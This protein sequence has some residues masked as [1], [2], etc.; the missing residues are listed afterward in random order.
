[1]GCVMG[2]CIF[3]GANGKL[4]REHIWADWLK[5][6]IPKDMP[7][8]QAGEIVRGRDGEVLRERGRRVGG[9]PRSRRVECVCGSITH[10]RT[11]DRK[12]C[13]DGW[14]SDIQAA[15]KPTVIPMIEGKSVLLRR[16]QQ[17]TFAAWVAMAAMCSEQGDKDWVSIREKDRTWLYKKKVPPQN[18]WKIWIGRYRRGKW[19]P[20]WVHHTLRI[21][22]RERGEIPFLGKQFFNTQ[23]TTYTVG[24]L[25]IH[26]ISSSWPPCVS[27]FHFRNADDLLLMVWPPRSSVLMWPP[28]AI[29]SDQ[30]GHEVATSFFET[31]QRAGRGP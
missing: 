11:P 10:R 1:M 23:S 3:C 13:N 17:R 7:D 21:V 22:K 24:E 20:H 4:T 29:L 28:P 31:L 6:Y 5:K 16:E 14:M 18:N 15:V 9:D 8:Y 30:Q 25:L 2:V 12:G 19:R 27:R 26:A